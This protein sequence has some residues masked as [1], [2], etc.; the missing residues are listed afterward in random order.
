MPASASQLGTIFTDIYEQSA[1]G[2]GSGSGSHPD[3]TREYRLYLEDFIQQYNVRTV[4][5]MGCG[6]WQSSHLVDWQGVD[7]LGLDV[8][9]D[10]I[11]SN[12]AHH[13]TDHVQFEEIKGFDDLPSADLLIVKDVLQ[14]WSDELIAQ[15]YPYLTRYKHFLITNTQKTY[16]IDTM[17][18]VDSEL[19]NKDIETGKMHPLD[20]SLPP[21][22]WSVEEA[23]VHMSIRRAK[24]KVERKVTYS[25]K[26]T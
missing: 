14:H 22:N 13:Q 19:F 9:G 8:V 20:L 1:W 23:F 26:I 25:R 16:Y 24:T 7:Y 12:R 2:N 5:D 21:Y 11:S 10:I 18:E 15:F 6:D 17:Q 3:N 4:V